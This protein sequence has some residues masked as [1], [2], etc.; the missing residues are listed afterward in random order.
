MLNIGVDFGS[1]YTTVSV[2][3]EE[4]KRLEAISFNQ[5]SPYIPSVVAYNGKKL[6]FGRAAKLHAGRK[7]VSVFKAFKMLLTETDEERLSK[8]GYGGAYTP[9]V[10]AKEFLEDLIHKALARTGEEKVDCLVVGAPEIWFQE[11]KTIAGR[12]VLRDICQEIPEILKVQVVSEP[13][14]ASAFFAYNYQ[15]ITG[16]AFDG[17]I[18]LVDYGG[19]TLDITLTQVIPSGTEEASSEGAPGEE[20]Q[21]MEIKVLESNGAGEN[22]DHRI[23]KAGIVYME[24]V[25]ACAIRRAGLLPEGQ[26]PPIDGPFL[27]VVNMLEDEL[28]SR[29]EEI[30]EFFEDCGIDDPEELDEEFTTISYQGEDLTITYALLAEVYDEVIRGVFDEK[31]QEMIAFMEKRGIDYMNR[32]QDTFKIALV[33][34]FGNFYLVKK[35]VMD[36]F[37]FTARD[38]R[39]SDIIKNKA[40]CEKAISLGTALL[41]SHVIGIRQTAPYSIGVFARDPSGNP[42]LDYAFCYKEDI[43]FNRAYFPVS[44][45]DGHRIVTFI[46]SNAISQFVINMGHD[47]RTAIIVP[48]KEEFRRRLENVVENEYRTAVVGFSLDPSEVVSVHI[49]E[50][51]LLEDRLEGEDHVIELT[52]FGELFDLTQ[53]EKVSRAR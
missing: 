16:R 8:R 35:Q 12:S 15:T 4:T 34:G 39:Q 5:D 9:A 10:I 19:G 32:T 17:N 25:A 51:D 20:R 26:E 11:V 37:R 38:R 49:Q 2:Y 53:V 44:A 28:Q 48:L 47:E 43:E 13:A 6:E 36:T 14:A 41:A 45:A 50:Y 22:V 46:A 42:C 23:G 27:R 7:G 3:R 21:Y 18:L 40:D 29:T 31:M 24:S 33:G 52:K 1:T 30:D